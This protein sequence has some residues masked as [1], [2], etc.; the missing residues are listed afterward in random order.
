VGT[1]LD[2]ATGKLS[3]SLNG[4]DLGVAFDMYANVASLLFY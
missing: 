4:K 1:L 2:L 3:F